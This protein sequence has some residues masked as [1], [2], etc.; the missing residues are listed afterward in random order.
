MEIIHVV[1]GKANPERMNGVNKVVH[2]LASKQAESGRT[3]SVWGITPSLEHNYGPRNFTTRL[4]AAHKN[5]FRL[6]T[7]LV[8]AVITK[9][10]NAVFHLH[11]GW[12]PAFS[13]LSKLLA[14][15]DI[16]F[17][18]T[19]HGAYN[20]IAM[21]RSHT[22]K[23]LYFSLFEKQL[24]KRVHRVH[25]IG[26]S[27]VSGL[28]KIF[29]T[30]KTF[31]LPYGYEPAPLTIHHPDAGSTF[32]VGFV[33]RLDVYTKGLDLLLDAFRVFNRRHPD[34]VLWMVGDGPDRKMLARMIE[35]RELEGVALL[36]GSKFGKEKD[37]LLK[38]MDVFAHPSRNEGLP[39]A[40]LE[41]AA[42][43]VPA[44]VSQATNVGRYVTQYN[45]GI[46]IDNENIPALAAAFKTLY[47][48]KKND[49]LHELGSNGRWMVGQA[50]NWKSIVTDFDTLYACA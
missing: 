27:E 10:G 17:V 1:L 43:G 35:Q 40:V 50:F 6:D 11:G 7:N 38:R 33:G 23:R 34:A 44:V 13:T 41:A 26:E 42:L 20:T 2:Q 12:I 39:T 9:K 45:A 49:T 46:V 22:L 3:V 25:C 16:P 47:D 4:F 14:D 37:D 36:W 32:V 8:V 31:L 19:P 18:I 29:P 5:P 28:T 48:R 24:L 21:R 30:Q 15:H